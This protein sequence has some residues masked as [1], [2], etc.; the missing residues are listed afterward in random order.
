LSFTLESMIIYID[1]SI[2]SFGPND[3]LTDCRR[4]RALAANPAQSKPR[5]GAAVRVERLVIVNFTISWYLCVCPVVAL[6]IFFDLLIER[7]IGRVHLNLP[8]LKEILNVIQLI[9]FVES[10]VAHKDNRFRFGKTALD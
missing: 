2:L 9:L 5:R 4:K 6:I 10:D 8:V 7:A 1:I 3:Q